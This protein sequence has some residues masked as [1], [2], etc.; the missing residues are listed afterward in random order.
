MTTA[1][2]LRTDLQSISIKIMRARH[3]LI[4]RTPSDTVAS[5]DC[6]PSYVCDW[7][8]ALQEMSDAASLL[9]M[10]SDLVAEEGADVIRGRM[11]PVVDIDLGLTDPNGRKA[12][13]LG[14]GGAA[15]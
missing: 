2:E 9:T 1:K 13:G 4:G 5:C 15:A 8:E 14:P 11:A 12:Q 3:L 6:T 7:H 10:M